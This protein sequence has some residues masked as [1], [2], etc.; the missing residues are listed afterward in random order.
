MSSHSI[1]PDAEVFGEF[2]LFKKV[3][4]LESV[5]PLLINTPFFSAHELCL[6]IMV[7]RNSLTA[8]GHIL[9]RITLGVGHN[10]VVVR[11]LDAVEIEEIFYHFREIVVELEYVVRLQVVANSVF[12][13]FYYRF[14][15]F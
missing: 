5:V 8:D 15:F 12:G 10:L 2:V 11:M 14:S 9:T 4:F 13:L 7:K 1:L 6:L 3:D